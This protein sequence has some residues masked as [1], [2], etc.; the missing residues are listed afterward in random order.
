MGESGTSSSLAQFKSQLGAQTH[1]YFE[2]RHETLPITAM[3]ARARAL[4][5]RVI[6]FR[7]P[8]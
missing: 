8:G 4:V 1:P 6:R 2:Y 3:D 5:K 7:E